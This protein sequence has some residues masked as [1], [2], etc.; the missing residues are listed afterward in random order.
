M[1]IQVEDSLA[2]LL[3][4]SGQNEAA[5]AAYKRLLPLAHRLGRM[6]PRDATA[7]KQEAFLHWRLAVSLRH[8]HPERGLEHA[9]QQMALMRQLMTRFPKDQVLKEEFVAG[10]T[11]AAS[12]LSADGSLDRAAEYYRQAIQMRED[13]LR[14]DPHSVSLQRNLVVNYSNY[15]ALLGNPCFPNLGRPAEGRP[16]AARAVTLA[17]AL[18]AAD[19]QDAAARFNLAMSLLRLGEIEPESNQESLAALR[20]AIAIMEPMARANPKSASIGV[21]LAAAREYAGHRLESLGKTEEAAEE[22]EA[23]LAVVE[24]FLPSGSAAAVT[25]AI[26]AE[27]ALALVSA[28][29]GDRQ[30]AL[31]YAHRAV[32]EGE[33]HRDKAPDLLLGRLAQSHWVLASVH[34]TFGER[35]QARAAAER[36]LEMWREVHNSGVLINYRKSM[37]DAT[38]LLAARSPK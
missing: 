36:A 14:A 19:P 24:S 15:S 26:A 13:L 7:A 20:E 23:S 25:Q 11:T 35:D 34:A 2:D 37:D 17:R 8:A 3:Y 5:A 27:Q 31:E 1:W 38:V 4:Q 16:L 33:R 22:Y 29:K 18:A 32:A 12:A 28:G 6:M 30:R 10:L 21:A 9:N